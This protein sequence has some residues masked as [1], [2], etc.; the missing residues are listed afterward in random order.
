MNSVAVRRYLPLAL[1]TAIFLVDGGA[2][3]QGAI[4]AEQT[5]VIE[6][7]VSYRADA[8]RPWR[9]GRYYIK[10]PK[11]GELA[12]AVVALHSRKLADTESQPQANTV[13]IDQKNFQFMPE[14]VAV[15]VGNSVKFTNSDQ[16]THN[17]RSFGDVASFNVTM[18]AGGSHTVRFDKAGGIRQP[19]Q[20]GCVFHSAMQ[21]N[22]FVFDHPWYELTD[23]SGKFRLTDVPPGQYELEMAHPAGS[24]RWRKRVEVKAGETLR[25]DIRVSPDDKM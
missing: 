23:A 4:A 17:V 24:L 18:P 15:R 8:K 1:A 20:V 11:T 14:T 16:A 9:Y 13:T 25:I 21:A 10:R 2:G 19:L 3:S 22:I 6:G 12:E 7:T 5:G